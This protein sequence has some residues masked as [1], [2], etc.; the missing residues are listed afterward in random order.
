MQ[1]IDSNILIYSGEAAYA[2]LLMPFVTDPANLVST[3]SKVE[4]LGY[5][6]VTPSQIQYFESLFIILQAIPVDDAVIQKAID[7]RRMKKISLGDSL[8]AATALIQGVEL[9]TRNTADFAGIPGL[10]VINPI[11]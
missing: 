1:L 9:V 3:I 7:I 2:P 8:I 10:K 6:H 11:P 4:T 5:V